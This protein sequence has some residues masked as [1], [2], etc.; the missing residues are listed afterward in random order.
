MV[1]VLHVN[2]SLFHTNKRDRISWKKQLYWGKPYRFLYW[3]RNSRNRVNAE[4]LHCK[5]YFM[6]LRSTPDHFFLNFKNTKPVQLSFYLIWKKLIWHFYKSFVWK[7]SFK[8]LNKL[9]H[10]LGNLLNQSWNRRRNAVIWLPLPSSI[11]F[12]V[13]LF[14]I[15]IISDPCSGN[16]WF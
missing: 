4:F 2:F 1:S 10:K 14:P 15:L 9:I 11:L 8:L 16:L 6:F 7:W 13:G 12:I 5:H 3:Y